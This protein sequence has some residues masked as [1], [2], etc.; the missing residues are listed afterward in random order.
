MSLL[1]I[2]SVFVSELFVFRLSDIYNPY[3]GFLHC[4][5]GFKRHDTETEDQ[6]LNWCSRSS[7]LLNWS[8]QSQATRIQ[9]SVGIEPIFNEGDS[10]TERQKK[11]MEAILGYRLI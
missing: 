6:V 9:T 11:L 4:D 2:Q 8:D 3:L 5:L 10:C 1:S 7:V